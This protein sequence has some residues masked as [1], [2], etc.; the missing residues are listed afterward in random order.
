MNIKNDTD[1]IWKS[2]II[3][4]KLFFLGY[5]STCCNYTF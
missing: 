4:M 3:Y 1:N 5:L 2:L